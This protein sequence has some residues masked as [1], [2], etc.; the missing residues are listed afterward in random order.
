[1][2]HICVHADGLPGSNRV[3]YTVELAV[4]WME[5]DFVNLFTVTELMQY[6]AE[7]PM[8]GNFTPYLLSVS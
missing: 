5:E 8:L 4:F 3:Q 1:M 2:I 6:A 7:L